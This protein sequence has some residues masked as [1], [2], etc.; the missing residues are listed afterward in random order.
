MHEP[1]SDSADAKLCSHFF[2]GRGRHAPAPAGRAS[3]WSVCGIRFRPTSRKGSGTKSTGRRPENRVP[4]QVS[5]H[6]VWYNLWPID[7]LG[8]WFFASARRDF[9]RPGLN[10]DLDALASTSRTP[11]M[12]Q[13]LSRCSLGLPSALARL[14]CFYWKFTSPS[15]SWLTSLTCAGEEGIVNVYMVSAARQVATLAQ[16][17]QRVVTWV[18]T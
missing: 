5:L 9:G 15:P 17:E 2:S 6:S 4:F 8:L 11:S 13:M 16:H 18:A 10:A 14:S 7:V 3:G 12:S 1:I